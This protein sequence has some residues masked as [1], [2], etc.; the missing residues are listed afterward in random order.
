MTQRVKG[1]GLKGPGEA[2]PEGVA[3]VVGPVPAPVR[4]AT[5]VGAVEPTPATV[6]P[7]TSPRAIL[8]RVVKVIIRPLQDVAGEVEKSIAIYL[9]LSDGMSL[10][11]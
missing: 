4:D 3:A 5:V 9:L 2:Q 8:S 11:S 10:L 1:Q 7:P 6:D